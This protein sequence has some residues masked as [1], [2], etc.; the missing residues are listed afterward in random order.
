[1]SRFEFRVWEGVGTREWA[2]WLGYDVAYWKGSHPVVKTVD[3][4]TL[5]KV[6]Q[7]VVRHESGSIVVL[8]ARAFEALRGL[9][10]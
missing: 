7:V 4:S 10:G 9:S 5:L 8:S 6:G 3:G 2:A 1:M